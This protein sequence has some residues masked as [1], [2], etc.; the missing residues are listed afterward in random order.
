MA[1]PFFRSSTN[2][3]PG[4]G[5]TTPV[6][7][8]T[9]GP[10]Y[11]YAGGTPPTTGGV[12]PHPTTG[13]PTAPTTTPSNG[14]NQVSPGQYA[15][16]APRAQ[17]PL[18]QAAGMGGGFGG[19]F[20]GPVNRGPQTSTPFPNPGG[21]AGPSQGGA[22]VPQRGGFPQS[23]TGGAY[24]QQPGGFGAKTYG[25]MNGQGQ[26]FGVGG[27]GSGTGD[28]RM[29]DDARNNLM[30]QTDQRSNALQGAYGQRYDSL[31][32]MLQGLG[33]QEKKDAQQRGQNMQSQVQGS[34][35]A[36][37]LSGTTL[38]DAGRTMVNNGTEAEMNR[39][40]ERLQGQALGLGTQLSGDALG[41]GER[42]LGQYAG[43]GQQNIRDSRGDYQDDRNFGEGQYR[44][45]RDFGF[46]QYQ[47]NRN[48]NQGVFQDARNFA[49]SN[50]SEDRNFDY[51]R[52]QDQWQQGM[53]ERQYNDSQ[54]R[55][56]QQFGYQQRMDD[57]GRMD[58]LGLERLG[59]Q[60]RRNDTYPDMGQMIDQYS[61]YGQYGR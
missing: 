52:S 49:D 33:T 22:P 41:Y 28:R 2:M 10:G 23:R 57:L 16:T 35:A 46:N 38:Q 44:N 60:E 43:M 4:Q 9:L 55:Y 21:F 13:T 14:F 45:D 53:Q 15:P 3:R 36:R 61:Q 58:R 19:R 47:D 48:F 1:T 37:G 59:F 6:T 56:N 27:T 30:Q 17:Q 18:Q 31:M 7:M 34:M 24:G 51:N 5:G 40:N 50:F 39:I 42:A 8:P 26:S 11:S 54:N 32:G 25:N 29:Y 12:T 20:N